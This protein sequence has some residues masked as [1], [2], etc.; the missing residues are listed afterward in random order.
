MQQINRSTT[1]KSADENV[2]T[3]ITNTHRRLEILHAGRLPL[4]EVVVNDQQQRG[5]WVVTYLVD[6]LDEEKW[7]C[8]P[9]PT[10]PSPNSHPHA[11]EGRTGGRARPQPTASSPTTVEISPP[12]A[13]ALSP[14]PPLHGHSAGDLGGFGSN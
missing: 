12:T 7:R 11:A 1:T 10:P 3:H 5:I 14:S 8:R 2:A 4:M 6:E 13:A 9:G